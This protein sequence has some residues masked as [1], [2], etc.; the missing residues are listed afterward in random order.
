VSLSV[1]DFAPVN[2][3]D[4]F[5]AFFND[6]GVISFSLFS[7]EVEQKHKFFDFEAGESEF[8]VDLTFAY[9]SDSISY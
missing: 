6:S 4:E 2:F 3:I 8:I 9:K 5:R 1:L 7:A